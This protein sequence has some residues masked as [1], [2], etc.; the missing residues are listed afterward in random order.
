MSHQCSDGSIVCWNQLKQKLH[1]NFEIGCISESLTIIDK[2]MFLSNLHSLLIFVLYPK[3]SLGANLA[4][5]VKKCA[6]INL[7]NDFDAHMFEGSSCILWKIL[8]FRFM[9]YRRQT[10][11][12]QNLVVLRWSNFTLQYDVQ[13][14][15]RALAMGN[16]IF[17]FCIFF[18]LWSR[19]GR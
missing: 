18:I 19:Y 13:H 4:E 3:L 14:C 11:G 7:I 16:Q 15:R 8:L 9:F 1:V 12:K 5:I 6:S 17:H 10:S 2:I